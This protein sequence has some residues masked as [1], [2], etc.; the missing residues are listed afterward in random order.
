M[1]Q[2]AAISSP[3]DADVLVGALKKRGYSVVV[4]R[5][6]NDALMHVQIGPFSNRADANAMRQKLAGDGYNAVLK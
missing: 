4:R 2:V 3:A 5:E 1:V 6:P